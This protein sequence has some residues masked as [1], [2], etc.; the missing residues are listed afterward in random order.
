MKIT[1]I[2]DTN[3]L[4]KV[5]DAISEELMNELSEINLLDIPWKKPKWQEHWERRE[6][7]H[8]RNDVLTAVV[9]EI[10]SHAKQVG[11]AVGLPVKEINSRFWLDTEGFDC[12][13]HIDNPAVIIAFQLYLVDCD[14]MGTVF[15][16][17]DEE[18]VT[19]TDDE[20]QW[21]WNPGEHPPPEVRHTFEFKKN[22][23]YI[24]LNNK[25]QLHGVP[26]KLEKGMLRLSA[27]C[28]CEI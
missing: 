7:Q 28:D 10:N 15:Y 19:T 17:L 1:P 11:E 5:E 12:H 16:H 4:Y 24:M 26:T 22:T 2:D 18:Q 8:E 13:P 27:Y 3:N 14:N 25:T 9:H 20:Q 21:H 23:G 6:I